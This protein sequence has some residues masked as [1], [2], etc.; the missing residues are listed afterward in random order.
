MTIKN[1]FMRSPVHEHLSNPDGTPKPK[2]LKLM[3]QLSKNEVGLVIPGYVY[4]SE[5]GKA[6]SNQCALYNQKHADACKPIQILNKVRNLFS[7][8]VM[9][10]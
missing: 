10:A 5:S 1:R 3:E 9:L 6:L 8:L 2:V 4:I 7:K